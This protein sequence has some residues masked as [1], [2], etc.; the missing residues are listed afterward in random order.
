MVRYLF[1]ELPRTALRLAVAI[2]LFGLVTQLPVPALLGRWVAI[3]ASALLAAAVLI[4]CGSLLYNT[5]FYERYW[6]QVDSR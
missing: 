1:R 3:A 5:L 4:I 2:A 6:R